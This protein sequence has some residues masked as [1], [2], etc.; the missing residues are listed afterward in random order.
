MFIITLTLIL[1]FHFGLLLTIQIITLFVVLFLVNSLLR[2]YPESRELL[3]VRI[4]AV[5]TI[6]FVVYINSNPMIS[7]LTCIIP[8]SIDK[9]TFMKAIKDRYPDFKVDWSS[10]STDLF[11]DLTTQEIEIFLSNL[12]KHS[13]Y[14]VEIEFHPDWEN[15]FKDL[16]VMI[17]SKPICV[18]KFSSPT[19]I[20]KYIT[21]RMDLMRDI[22]FNDDQII[23]PNK[24]GFGPI[25]VIHFY[26]FNY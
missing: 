16:P 21:Q 10:Y 5:L 25:I 17:L 7:A 1:Y 13:N 11:H 18:N 15:T 22:F 3:V 20:R 2:V 6:I 12:D 4:L 23:Q 24:V 8:L 26:K 9:V 19:T 14:I